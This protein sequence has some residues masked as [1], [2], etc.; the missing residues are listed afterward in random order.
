METIYTTTVTTTGSR[1]GHVKSADGVL[2]FIVKPP[3]EMGGEGEAFTNPEQLFAAGYSSCFC[4]AINF[5]ALTKKKRV[6]SSVKIT[7]SVKNNENKGFA[8]AVKLDI[9]ISGVNI[10]EAK[11]LVEEAKYV[12]P[13][14]NATRG[15]IE[16]DYTV[17]TKE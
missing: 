6:E 17:S 10:Q 5:V 4:R 13:Y 1:E 14:S 2:D 12:C 3:K 11:E 8:F 15:N 16:T 7:V 9:V